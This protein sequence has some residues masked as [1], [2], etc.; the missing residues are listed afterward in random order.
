MLSPN[1]L[2]NITAFEIWCWC[3]SHVSIEYFCVNATLLLLIYK[4]KYNPS[5]HN[6][7]CWYCIS[8]IHN[9]LVPLSSC[10]W[11]RI[12]HLFHPRIVKTI[13]PGLLCNGRSN[14]IRTTAILQLNAVE[15]ILQNFHQYLKQRITP[16]CKHRILPRMSST[17]QYP[18]V[19]IRAMSVC[20]RVM[21]II[22]SYHA[23]MRTLWHSLIC[24]D[25][26]LIH[27]DNPTI[28]GTTLRHE[29]ITSMI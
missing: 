19:G 3:N 2:V 18:L 23:Y 25:R 12:I 9:T 4:L 22:M 20:R 21:Y 5:R 15:D 17:I 27:A 10:S 24:A 28:M 29:H 13:F 16:V 6:Q 11:G 1:A 14:C 8:V 7:Y 26:L